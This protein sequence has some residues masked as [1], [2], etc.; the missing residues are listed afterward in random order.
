MKD[1]PYALFKLFSNHHFHNSRLTATGVVCC[2]I[3]LV[4][5]SGHDPNVDLFS[6]S[7]FPFQGIALKLLPGVPLSGE[8]LSRAVVVVVGKSADQKLLK[9][10][11][12]C[13][14]LIQSPFL[15]IVVS[16]LADSDAELFLCGVVAWVSVD[17]GGSL[18][19][20]L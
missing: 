17:A 20:P 6:S 15:Q 3:Q 8:A 10:I 13:P 19:I 4:P 5:G 9:D 11:R 16:H 14:L 18:E 1:Y 2:D 12:H 7:P